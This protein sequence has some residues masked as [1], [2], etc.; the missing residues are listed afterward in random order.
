MTLF[1]ERL[2]P[3]PWLFIALGLVIPASL[4][5]FAPF[6]PFTGV[7][8]ALVLYLG[9]VIVLI[10]SSP[11]IVLTE[12]NLRAGKAQIP[13]SLLRKP[14]AFTGKEAFRQRGTELDARA[15]LCIRGW[16]NPVVKIP[17][18]DPTDPVPYWLLSTRRPEQFVSALTRALEKTDH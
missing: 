12:K 10:I 2:S 9:S 18:N 14:V 5:V 6:S 16:I 4:L 1:Q 17:L 15:W 13:I 7:I 11:R 8:V 3:T